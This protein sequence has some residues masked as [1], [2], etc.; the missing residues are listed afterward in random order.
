MRGGAL[1]GAY[2]V[3]TAVAFACGSE[4]SSTVGAADS[5]APDVLEGATPALDGGYCCVPDP[6]PGCCMTYGGWSES[7]GCAKSC[8]GMPVPST[9]GWKLVDDEHGCK[10]WSQPASG[11]KCGQASIPDAGNDA[12]AEDSGDAAPD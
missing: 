8:D 10:V 9:P 2:V 7:G 4:E 1:A 6:A 5:G 12:G 11:A 3:M